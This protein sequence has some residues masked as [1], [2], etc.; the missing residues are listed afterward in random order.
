[1]SKNRIRR[2]AFFFF[3]P[4]LGATYILSCNQVDKGMGAFVFRDVVAY[5]GVDQR[6]FQ[7][8]PIDLD[9]SGS[10]SPEGQSLTYRWNQIAGPETDIRRA[11]TFRATV[12]PSELGEYVFEL[13]VTGSEGGVSTDQ[14]TLSIV[15]AMGI[16]SD[17]F[18]AD[19]LPSSI[20]PLADLLVVY[21]L[22]SDLNT[23][24]DDRVQ[25]QMTNNV[26]H[27][28]DRLLL[29]ALYLAPVSADYWGKNL[30][31]S[32]SFDWGQ[33][34]SWEVVSGDYDLRAL[35]YRGREYYSRIGLAQSIDSWQISSD[36]AIAE[37]P[38]LARARRLVGRMKLGFV[39]NE[40]EYVYAYDLQPFIQW[41]TTNLAFEVRGVSHSDNAPVVAVFDASTG[42]YRLTHTYSSD[43]QYR[44][45]FE[46]RGDQVHGAIELRH[47][48]SETD[49][50]VVVDV[51][52]LNQVSLL[53]SRKIR[54]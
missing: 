37:S 23:H 10:K 15:P 38:D 4:L 49:A 30:L 32:S 5:A 6:L 46:L 8:L 17:Y 50:W 51:A 14:V 22:A 28:G 42:R 36:S 39:H 45:L 43:K 25:L 7:Y 11:D 27:E 41:D 16:G 2:R 9:G 21:A 40:I 1:M 12:A 18:M 34:L 48:G 44:Y 3:V 52:P 35:D 31:A 47:R 53:V 33:S 29:H 26:V 24:S 13:T 19:A 20:D 54:K